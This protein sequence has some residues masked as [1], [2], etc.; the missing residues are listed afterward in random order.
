MREIINVSSTYNAKSRVTT[1]QIDM[2][3]KNEAGM[4]VH[5]ISCIGRAKWNEKDAFDLM[6]GIRIAYER[7]ISQMPKENIIEKC[8]GLKDGD[9]V[10][11]QSKSSSYV[12][13]GIIFHN[14]I[15]YII[16]SGNWDKISDFPKGET[17]FDRITTVVR[18]L[19]SNPIT[20]D[21]VHLG[22]YKEKYMQDYCKVYEAD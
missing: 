12:T 15:L 18:P 11:I 3:E 2:S 14:N 10:R 20:L 1:V 7:A 19:G 5:Y 22:Q 4:L 21:T 17:Q 6:E 9:W 13:W 16:G 8:G